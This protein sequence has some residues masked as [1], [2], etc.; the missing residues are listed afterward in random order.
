[1]NEFEEKLLA[2]LRDKNSLTR[3]MIRELSAICD[4]LACIKE[5]KADG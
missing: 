5:I 4:E 3:D 1:M 2:E